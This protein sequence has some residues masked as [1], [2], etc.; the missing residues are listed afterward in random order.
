MVGYA[1]DPFAVLVRT[2]RM[3]SVCQAWTSQ[4]NPIS[5][6]ECWRAHLVRPGSNCAPLIATIELPSRDEQLGDGLGTSPVALEL[7]I[8]IVEVRPAIAHRPAANADRSAVLLA[9]RRV[10][11]EDQSTIGY[12]DRAAF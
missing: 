8:L 12:A 4:A 2:S 7:F 11:V 1:L 10:R 6:V 9:A 5:A 3:N